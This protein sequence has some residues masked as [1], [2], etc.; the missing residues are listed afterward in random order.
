MKILIGKH[1]GVCVGFHELTNGSAGLRPMTHF[2]EKSFF[3]WEGFG[4]KINECPK[5][6]PR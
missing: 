4:Q 3:C 1:Q 6:L 2:L 5:S